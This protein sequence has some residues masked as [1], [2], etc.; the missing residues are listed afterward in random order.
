MG[1]TVSAA[2]GPE[3]GTADRS[4]T[5]T[6]SRPARRSMR[7][8]DLLGGLVED[9]GLV[10]QKRK[11]GNAVADGSG[12]AYPLFPPGFG[13]ESV[14]STGFAL[15][16][17]SMENAG[18]EDA[19]A[20]S[21]VTL[22][23]AGAA[24]FVALPVAPQMNP[25]GPAGRSVAADVSGPVAPSATELT[26]PLDLASVGPALAK[27][28]VAP[29]SAAPSAPASEDSSPTHEAIS[30]EGVRSIEERVAA[31]NGGRPEVSDFLTA[32]AL[33]TPKQPQAAEPAAK[34][35]PTKTEDTSSFGTDQLAAESQEPDHG[36]RLRT[37]KGDATA[38]VSPEILV[39]PQGGG[40][41]QGRPG[42]PTQFQGILPGKPH[43][44]TLQ[45]PAVRSWSEL[46]V[47]SVS[48]GRPFPEPKANTERELLAPPFPEAGTGPRST[49]AADAPLSPSL[50]DPVRPDPYPV[51][52]LAVEAVASANAPVGASAQWPGGQ[53]PAGLAFTARV[54][55]L[56]TAEDSGPATP[57]NEQLP[58]AKTAKPDAERTPAP[59]VARSSNDPQKEDS[60][61]GV[62]AADRA[63]ATEARN[64]S[65]PA[66]AASMQPP[67][68]STGESGTTEA[69]ASPP[70]RTGVAEGGLNAAPA[71]AP[72][73]EIQLQLHQ[74]EQRVDVRLTEHGGEV[75]VAVRTPDQQLAGA[76]RADLPALSTR[77]EQTGFRA[78][79]WHPAIFH[80]S[81]RPAGHLAPSSSDAPDSQNGSQRGSQQQPDPRQQRPNT[82]HGAKSQRKEFRWLMSQLP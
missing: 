23:P 72:T 78:E 53:A 15:K 38:A 49:A 65:W 17:G 68:P 7:F 43:S 4:R 70:R 10:E 45:R 51:V 22:S 39:P 33:E 24:D 42:F 40:R 12:V 44:Q 30:P 47:R 35:P 56:S 19:I 1:G 71:A 13:S 18:S 77:L 82:A 2:Q 25:A 48:G 63:Q 16:L 29:S 26:G 67:A 27:S 75:R 36:M 81:V 37:A 9:N 14:R 80:E 11:P 58:A 60:L 5:G 55:P 66:P 54:V 50:S 79:T 59:P 20:R 34:F 74:G 61:R 76:L 32:W 21:P 57:G 52:P 62:P 28:A 3:P 46:T 6:S 69:E 8:S 41:S 31:P 64:L 73:R